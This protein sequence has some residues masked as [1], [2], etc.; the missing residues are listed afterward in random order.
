MKGE[1]KFK[2]QEKKIRQM[3]DEIG[4]LKTENMVLKHENESLRKNNETARKTLDGMKIEYDQLQKKCS[5][6]IKE[7]IEMRKNY[8]LLIAECVAAKNEYTRSIGNLVN[9]IRGERG[10]RIRVPGIILE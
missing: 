9:R 7:A 1:R 5:A 8:E 6:E 4:R 10:Q 2:Y 3:G